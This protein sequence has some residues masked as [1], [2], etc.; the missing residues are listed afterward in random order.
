M[1]MQELQKKHGWSW[2]DG[3]Y[4][5]SVG[6]SIDWIQIRRSLFNTVTPKGQHLVLTE[7]TA[8]SPSGRLFMAAQG[9]QD[10]E[11]D[12]MGVG[13]CSERLLQDYAGSAFAANVCF[14]VILAAL[15]CTR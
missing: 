10:D 2:M 6:Q 5:I 3:T 13:E 14:V 15:L 11:L 8:L 9:I 7:G 12:F 1:K 4:G